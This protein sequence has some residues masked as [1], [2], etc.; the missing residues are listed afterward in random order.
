M[1]PPRESS[2]YR[3]RNQSK[4]IFYNHSTKVLYHIFISAVLSSELL[5]LDTTIHTSLAPSPACPGTSCSDFYQVLSYTVPTVQVVTASSY[6]VRLL[7]RKW[8]HLLPSRIF[9]SCPSRKNLEKTR[10]PSLSQVEKS[11]TRFWYLEL[12]LIPLSFYSKPSLQ[13]SKPY[14]YQH[15]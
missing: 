11:S 2:P 9:P 4:D 12:I 5:P 7:S 6:F 3:K 13:P 10:F 8:T 15:S 14:L 1:F